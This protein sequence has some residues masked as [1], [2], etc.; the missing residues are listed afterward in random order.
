MRGRLGLGDGVGGPCSYRVDVESGAVNEASVPRRQHPPAEPVAA[1]PFARSRADTV[2]A[3]PGAVRR[4]LHARLHLRAVPDGIAR[5]RAHLW[6]IDRPA[7]R[8]RPGA[9]F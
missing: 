7:F 3:A 9:L 2:A 6:R 5:T 4:H 8:R 1:R